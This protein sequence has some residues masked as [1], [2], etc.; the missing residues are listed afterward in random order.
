LRSASPSLRPEQEPLAT[1]LKYRIARLEQKAA[2]G[3]EFVV[4]RVL[5]TKGGRH[6]V[7]PP[8]TEREVDAERIAIASR[9]VDSRPGGSRLPRFWAARGNGY[10]MP[11]ARLRDG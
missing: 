11:S 1:G 3:V 10:N 9:A 2:L 5:R 6:G 4:I 8:A 7:E